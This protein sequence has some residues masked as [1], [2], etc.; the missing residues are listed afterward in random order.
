MDWQAVASA[1][2]TRMAELDVTQ[3][4]LSRRSG[5]SVA[6]LRT[7]QSGESRRRSPRT[8]S[9]VSE[10]LGW[11]SGHLTAVA[12]GRP[13]QEVGSS[14]APTAEALHLAVQAL[15]ARLEAVE[16]RLPAGER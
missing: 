15:E 13:P 11:P 4:D 7:L 1:M 2:N 12:E 14:A 3:V 16:R 9:A 6:T 8:L 10:A 5:V